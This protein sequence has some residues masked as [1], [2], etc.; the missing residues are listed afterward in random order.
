[1]REAV[2]KAVIQKMIQL[3]KRGYSRLEIAHATGYAPETVSKYMKKHQ[4]SFSDSRTPVK[5][6]A[7]TYIF[8]EDMKRCNYG[9]EI[10]DKVIV[11]ERT[12]RDEK[13]KI[14]TKT[15][16]GRVESITDFFTVIMTE[17]KYRIT[18]LKVDLATKKASITKV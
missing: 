9:V 11:K 4:Y 10:G 16:N 18:V 2:P 15:C 12:A 13:G 8:A 3:Y 6:M 7:K 14:I 5:E 1:M 17:R